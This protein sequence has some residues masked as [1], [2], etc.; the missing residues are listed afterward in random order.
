[1][2]VVQRQA[3]LTGDLAAGVDL[4]HGVQWVERGL[5]EGARE[6]GQRAAQWRHYNTLVLQTVGAGTGV[7]GIA[8]DDE[9]ASWPQIEG[10][11]RIQGTVAIV[12]ADHEIL[13]NAVGDTRSAVQLEKGIEGGGDEVELGAGAGVY[14]HAV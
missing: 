13:G 11:H 2:G 5:I 1:M 9:I 3:D 4:D 7:T 14:L 12:V 8:H 10:D 6:D